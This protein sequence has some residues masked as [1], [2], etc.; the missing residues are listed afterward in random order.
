[1]EGFGG[2]IVSTFTLGIE[3]HSQPRVY[4]PSGAA[5]TNILHEEHQLLFFREDHPSK[6]PRK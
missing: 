2:K 4:K 6:N 5:L 3:L 1:M